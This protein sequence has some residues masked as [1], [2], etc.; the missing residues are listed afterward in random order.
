MASGTSMRSAASAITSIEMHFNAICFY[1]L[2]KPIKLRS[3]K[4]I[5]SF[6][7]AKYCS[8]ATHIL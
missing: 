7:V 6:S 5:S 3:S 4:N 8:T 1:V 2:F